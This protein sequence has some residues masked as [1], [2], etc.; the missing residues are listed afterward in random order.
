MSD[1]KSMLKYL[2]AREGLSQADLAKKLGVAKSTISMYELGKREP[3]FET[4]E[5]LADLFNVDMN[6]L[7][8]KMGSETFPTLPPYDN[9]IPLQK[10]RIPIL[11]E[12]A[13]G[14]PIFMNEER[15]VYVDTPIKAD[16]AVIAR[17]DSMTG[18]KI[19]NGDLVFIR[20]Q[21]IVDNGEIAVVAID[22]EA[23]LKR[24]Y[25]YQEKAL[26]ILKAENPKYEDLI[27][28]N[29]E[30]DHVHIL[31]KAVAFQSYIE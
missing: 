29:E 4:M 18:A 23:T 7:H 14:K 6:F 22:D 28:S 11:G 20:Q 17:G 10:Q 9:I 3:D 15:E 24:F 25:Y 26:M 1:F 19:M 12:V 8:G 16:F 2:R 13:A 5:S 27:Y 30:L 21:A 31:G